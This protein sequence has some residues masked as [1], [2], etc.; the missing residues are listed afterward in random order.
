HQPFQLHSGG[1]R[2]GSVSAETSCAMQT[3]VAVA[4]AVVAGAVVAGAVVQTV[5]HPTLARLWSRSDRQPRN[6]SPAFEVGLRWPRTC[7]GAGPTVFRGV[8][9]LRLE[10]DA[11]IYT[12]VHID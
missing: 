10:F 12:G 6:N 7:A 4:G 3:Q 9:L 8:C 2:H 11:V 1:E 5:W